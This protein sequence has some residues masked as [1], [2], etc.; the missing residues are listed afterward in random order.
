[1]KNE[2]KISKEEAS[3]DE[4]V[5]TLTN[6][7]V[8]D[9]LETDVSMVDRDVFQAKLDQAKLGM[10]FLRDRELMRRAQGGQTIRIMTLVY[11]NPEQRKAYIKASMP[12]IKLIE[13]KQQ[14][15]LQH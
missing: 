8:V 15:P 1:M 2:P 9:L 11:D 4:K 12:E 3:L 6:K 10:V 14:P 13:D 5:K 7:R